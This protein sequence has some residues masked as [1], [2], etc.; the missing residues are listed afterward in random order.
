MLTFSS[1]VTP[2]VSRGRCGS[3]Q[4]TFACLAVGRINTFRQLL[5]VKEEGVLTLIQNNCVPACTVRLELYRNRWSLSNPTTF[6][7]ANYRS[8]PT[9]VMCGA[10]PKV[11]MAVRIRTYIFS[12]PHHFGDDFRITLGMTMGQHWGHIWMTLGQFWGHIGMT[13]GQLWDDFEVTLG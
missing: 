13:L 8:S 2:T 9:Y 1:T 7:D 12:D 11:D 4:N 3:H 6:R 5:S 10:D